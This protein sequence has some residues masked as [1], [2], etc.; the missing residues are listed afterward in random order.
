MNYGDI[1]LN[2]WPIKSG[3]IRGVLVGENVLLW[4]WALR[5]SVLRLNSVQKKA[6]YFVCLQKSLLLAD[7]GLRCR[8]LSSSSTISACTLAYFPPWIMA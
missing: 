4:G 1:C 8:T 6:T 3:T 5:S 2:D 7:F